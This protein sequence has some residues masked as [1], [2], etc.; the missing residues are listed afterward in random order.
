MSRPGPWTTASPAQRSLL[1]NHAASHPAPHD[2][3]SHAR[4][5][6]LA[7]RRP[8]LGLPAPSAQGGQSWSRGDADGAAAARREGPERLRPPLPRGAAHCRQSMRWQKKGPVGTHPLRP[9]GGGKK[10]QRQEKPPGRT[11]GRAYTPGEQRGRAE[12]PPR[13]RRGRPLTGA[14]AAGL[15]GLRIPAPAPHSS[16][17]A[18]PDASPLPHSP[19]ESS[20]TNPG[21]FCLLA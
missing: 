8:E 11:G 12:A 2:T 6:R 18:W 1:P 5:K 9:G 17:A 15:G 7:H 13:S 21:H 14:E 10:G 20:P 4:A 3:R 19:T 16:A